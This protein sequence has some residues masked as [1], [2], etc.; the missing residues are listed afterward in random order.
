MSEFSTKAIRPNENNVQGS[1]SLPRE[2]GECSLLSKN[3]EFG[4][5]RVA[6]DLA[7]DL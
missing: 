6:S 5:R 4:I 1:V 7:A 3:L 2:A